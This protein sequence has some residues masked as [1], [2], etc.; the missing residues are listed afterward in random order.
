VGTIKLAK[1]QNTEF[2]TRI[3]N[4]ITGRFDRLDPSLTVRR[5]VLKGAITEKWPSVNQVLNAKKVPLIVP[6][7]WKYDSHN[8]KEAIR[9]VQKSLKEL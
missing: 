3:D 6:K 7:P 9:E 8:P 4:L 2:K 1:K 5:A